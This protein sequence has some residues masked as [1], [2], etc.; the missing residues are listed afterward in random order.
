M[1]GKILIAIA[2]ILLSLVSATP[3]T[4][5][6]LAPD[7]R[8][9][10]GVKV[11]SPTRVQAGKYFQVKL[12]SRKGKINGVCWW[13]WDV[14][15]GFSSPG[16]FKMKNGSATTKVLP[17]QPGAGTMSFLCGTSRSNPIAG[18]YAD[19]YIAP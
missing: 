19:I 18:G 1:L 5:D 16:D 4:A 17:I 3:A 8:M 6:Y 10:D 12:T 2:S 11:Q 14:S 7:S 13:Q 9:I 15:K